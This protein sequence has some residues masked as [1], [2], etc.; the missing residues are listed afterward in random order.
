MPIFKNQDALIAATTDSHE[1]LKLKNALAREQYAYE[2]YTKLYKL[3][4][5]NYNAIIKTDNK[6]Y[7]VV[8]WS[9]KDY[10]GDIL[11]WHES[12]ARNIADVSNGVKPNPI[13]LSLRDATREGVRTSR[14]LSV[15]TLLRRL[16]KA[17]K[18]IEQHILNDTIAVIPYRRGSRMYDR[19]DYLDIRTS[20]FRW[21]F[22]AVVQ[23]LV[24][25]VES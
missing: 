2:E 4:N 19:V 17:Q 5:V 9:A 18:T 3:K 10:L 21:H 14:E 24:H 8:G 1:K 22:W 7:L 25:S 23:S 11:Y 16:N 6:D 15:S 13:K 20:E 12:F